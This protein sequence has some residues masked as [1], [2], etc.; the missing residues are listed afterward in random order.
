MLFVVHKLTDVVVPTRVSEFAF[1]VKFSLRE[2]SL[3]DPISK[4][5][6]SVSIFLV[7]PELP[8]ILVVV[9]LVS[10]FTLPVLHVVLEVTLV[11][12]LL[13]VVPDLPHSMKLVVLELALVLEL[14]FN[15]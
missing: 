1:A 10:E 2:K 3:I 7:V 9:A 6:H 15:S 11:V 5:V 13:L 14:V 12:I 4:I 8:L